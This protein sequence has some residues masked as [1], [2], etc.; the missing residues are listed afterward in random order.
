MYTIDWARIFTRPSAKS[1]PR[2]SPVVWYLGL[3]SFFTD[4]SSEMVSS[5]LPIYLVSGLHLTPIAF[6]TIDGLYQ[7]FA[8]I[9][10]LGRGYFADRWGSHKAVASVGYVLSALCR[11][12]LLSAGNAWGLLV[13]TI[14]VD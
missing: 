14:A 4:I 10:R 9:A 11:I 8:A 12:V 5:I 2:V 1:R 3:T 7:G 13:A 6:G